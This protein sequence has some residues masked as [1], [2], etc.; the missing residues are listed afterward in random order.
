MRA[1]SRWISV[2]NKLT[3]APSKCRYAIY[4]KLLCHNGL[5]DSVDGVD[6]AFVD[7]MVMIT[8]TIDKRLIHW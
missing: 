6:R 2:S 8:R 3:F 5:Q 4:G 7:D 1:I